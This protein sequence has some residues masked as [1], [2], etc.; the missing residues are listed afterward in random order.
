VAQP[1]HQAGSGS[2]E[3]LE[4]LPRRSAIRSHAPCACATGKELSPPPIRPSDAAGKA[5]VIAAEKTPKS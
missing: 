5:P 4:G 2:S 3:Y 1:V